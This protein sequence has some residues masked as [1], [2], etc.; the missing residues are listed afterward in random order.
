MRGRHFTLACAASVV[1]ISAAPEAQAQIGGAVFARA[2]MGKGGDKIDRADI[3]EALLIEAGIS[4]SD[5]ISEVA[6]TVGSPA[7]TNDALLVTGVRAVRAN[8]NDRRFS[9]INSGMNDID[10]VL[11]N[12]PSG[13]IVENPG[14]QRIT[15]FT[16]A[17]PSWQIT[18]KVADPDE[19]ITRLPTAP[20]RFA[21]RETPEELWLGGQEARS[22][23]ALSLGFERSRTELDDGTRKTE[24]SFSVAGTAGLRLTRPGSPFGHIYLFANYDLQ[25]DRTRPAPV[26]GA[27]ESQGDGDTNALAIGFDGALRF[28]LGGNAA[29]TYIGLN[30]QTSA[31]FDFANDASRLRFRAI[32]TPHPRWDLGLC[33]L[34]SFSAGP[35]RARCEFSAEVQIAHVTRRGT[36]ELGNYD[37]F[38]AAGGRAGIDFFLPTQ[39]EDS[40]D[41]GFLGSVR[42]RFLHVL[43][44]APDDIERLEIKLAHR[45]WTAGNVGIDVGFTYTRGTNELSFENENKL[46]FGLGLIY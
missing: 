17:P 40:P 10:D 46:T 37:T 43:H 21:I 41:T 2:C 26:L 34:G 44:G 32:V 1:A 9:D 39:G 42:Y 11:N 31:V 22:A 45:F 6:E 25:R 12:G 36:T 7:V 38:L 24:T 8:P 3:A 29:E 23:G 13:I 27:G 33:R 20:P 18:C 14:G 19:P 5:F 4:P 16:D 28:P 30:L 15:V 35:L